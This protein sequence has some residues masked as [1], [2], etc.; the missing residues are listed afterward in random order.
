MMKQENYY[1]LVNSVSNNF[2]DYIVEQ[3]IGRGA[4]SFVVKVKSRKNGKEYAIKVIDK[5]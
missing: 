1:N 3:P 5:R 2:G 4:C